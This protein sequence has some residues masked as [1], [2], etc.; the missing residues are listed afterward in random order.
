M[1][2]V[3]ALRDALFRRRGGSPHRHR[4]QRRLHTLWPVLF[5]IAVLALLGLCVLLL[6]FIY[7]D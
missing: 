6:Q 1:K 4:A 7:T 5:G 3:N 2:L